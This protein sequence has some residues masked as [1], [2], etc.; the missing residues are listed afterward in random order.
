MASIIHDRWGGLVPRLKPLALPGRAAQVAK[1]VNLTCGKLR[2]A[3]YTTP[4]QRLHD[5]DGA[6]VGQL[7]PY[8]DIVQVTKPAA[9][10]ATTLAMLGAAATWCLPYAGV[11]ATYIDPDDSTAKVMEL[12]ALDALWSPTAYPSGEGFTLRARFLNPVTGTFRPNIVYRIHGPK[13]QLR[14]LADGKYEGGPEDAL[15]VPADV[16]WSSSPYPIVNIPLSWPI[17]M[18]DYPD[19][20]AGERYTYAYAS[21]IDVGGPVCDTEVYH[22][23]GDSVDID[24]IKSCH[25]EFFFKLDYVRNSEQFVQYVRT[26]IDQ[27]VVYGELTGIHNAGANTVTIDTL[28]GYEEDIPESGA[29]LLEPD[30]PA[31]LERIEYTS[32]TKVASTYVFALDGVLVK[33]HANN[34]RVNVEDVENEDM[35]GPPSELTDVISVNPGEI[36][37]ITAPLAARYRQQKIYRTEDAGENSLLIDGEVTAETMLYDAPDYFFFDD[38]Q[39]A[40][41]KVLPP[42]GNYPHDTLAEACVNSVVH[43]NQWAAIIHKNELRPSDVMR[44]HAYPEE[45]AIRFPTRIMAI[46]LSGGSIVVF[47]EADSTTNEQG[48]VFIL[49]GGDPSQLAMYEVANVSPLLI[50][51]SIARVDDRVYYASRD[52]IMVVGGGGTPRLITD[53]LFDRPGWTAERPDLMQAWVND[54]ALFLLLGAPESGMFSG[55]YLRFDFDADLAMCSRFTKLENIQEFEWKSRPFDLGHLCNLGWVQVQADNYPVIVMLYDDRDMLVAQRAVMGPVPERMPMTALS[56]I[57]AYRV[58][59]RTTVHRIAL[60]TSA[61]ELLGAS[62]G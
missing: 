26:Y 5:D 44:L 12:R 23:Q 29:L 61:P 25:V 22:E 17:S 24:V 49:S 32:Y 31:N 20:W 18:E 19:E 11:W 34:S 48:K 40:P 52:G 35:E 30:T 38:F 47:T 42:Y 28:T 1:N 45:W 14:F 21:L 6:M 9:L 55:N 8:L 60:A 27:I 10:T 53:Q 59:A 4:F 51:T 7:V 62:I 58:K 50:K 33:G 57:W 15:T 54:R 56:R 36:V 16:D 43:P 39:Q 41:S 13:Y 2:P 46:T 3:T 37:Q